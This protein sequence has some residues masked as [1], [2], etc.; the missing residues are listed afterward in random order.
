MKNYGE[1]RRLN[2]ENV[3]QLCRDKKWYTK[4]SQEEYVA[5]LNKIE[6]IAEYNA[7]ITANQLGEIAENILEH[8]D[9]TYTVESIMWELNR[10]ANTSFYR[11][12]WWEKDYRNQ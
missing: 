3:C 5:L 9:T 6:D 1:I 12:D 7:S 2:A 11:N 10:V 4:G 8:S